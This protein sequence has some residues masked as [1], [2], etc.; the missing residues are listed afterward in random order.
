MKRRVDTP[1]SGAHFARYSPAACVPPD[2]ADG[3][4]LS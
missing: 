2:I 4:P 1:A 3:R